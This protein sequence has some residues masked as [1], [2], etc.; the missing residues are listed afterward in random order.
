M[1]HTQPLTV[2]NTLPSQK[3]PPKALPLD[4]PRSLQRLIRTLRML[5][6]LTPRQLKG[7]MQDIQINGQDLM[8]WA[9]FDHSPRDS[10]GRKLVFQG[11]QFEIMVMSWLPGDFSAIH[12]H[13]HAQWGAV[14]CFGE[15]E[16]YIY[17]LEGRTLKQPVAAHYKCGDIHTIDGDVIHQMGNRGSSPFLSLHVYGCEH[18]DSSITGSAR[19]FDLLENST[20]FTNGGVFFCL[21][22]S[23]ITRREY[24]LNGDSETVNMQSVLMRDRIRKILAVEPDVTLERKIALLEAQMQT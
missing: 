12:D 9:D 1:I 15:A 2:P 23:S 14:Q 21:P 20:Q 24:G 19:V 16:H 6:P 4:Y 5:S 17:T 10:Y 11:G 13:G 7:V 8:R 3:S 18:T 22:E